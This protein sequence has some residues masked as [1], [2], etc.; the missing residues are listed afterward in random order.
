MPRTAHA[1]SLRLRLFLEGIEVPVIA[2]NVQTAPNSPAVA[3]IQVPPLAS[4]TKLHPRTCVHLFFLDLYKSS[5]AINDTGTGLPPDDGVR[6]PNE[7]ERAQSRQARG[8]EKDAAL[9]AEAVDAQNDQWRLLFGGEVVGFTWTKNSSNR[10]VILQCEDWSN[11]WDYAFQ[12][13]NDGIFGPGVKAVFSGA[14]TN[15]FTDFLSTE[16]E[17][18]T[19]IVSSGKCNT[20]PQLSGLAAGIIRLVEAISG[21][22]YVYPSGNR[23]KPPKRRAGQNLFFSYNELRLHLTQ[24]IGTVQNDPTSERIMRRSGYNGMFQRTIGGQGGQ[25][26]IRK[27]MTAL[28]KIIFYEMFPQPCP[29]YNPGNYGE[30]SGTRRVKMK[31][32]PTLSRFATAANDAI[33]SLDSLAADLDTFGADDTFPA[34]TEPGRVGDNFFGDGAPAGNLNSFQARL[35]RLADNQV[36]EL[37]NMYRLLQRTRA[38]MRNVPQ[39]AVGS[40]SVAVQKVGR[41][42]QK[43]S[44]LRFGGGGSDF[45]G[46]SSPSSDQ[47]IVALRDLYNEISAE[48]QKVADTETLIGVGPD[49]KPAQL[50]QQVFRPDIWFGA[51]PR[52]N[53]LFPELYHTFSYQ[54][55]FLRE[56]TRFMLKTNDEFF[57]ESV[58]FD[59][60]FYAPQAQTVKGNR[61]NMRSIIGRE[62][63]NHERFTGILPIF[64][65]QGEFNIF[66]SQAEPREGIKLVGLA[67]RSANFLYFRHRFNSR[68]ATCVGKFN[69]YLAVGCPGLIIDK[70]VDQATI[71]RHNEL[72][73]QQDVPE[74]EASQILGTNF[75]G[76]FQ[77]V[78]HQISN[79]QPLGET[80]ITLTFPR[81]PD[82]SVEFLGSVPNDARVRKRIDGA[83]AVKSTYVAAID[84]PQLFSLGPNRGRITNVQLVTDQYLGKELETFYSGARRSSEFRPA[85][86]PIGE[87]IT[88]GD[89]GNNPTV[90]TLLG[91]DDVTGVFQAYLVTEEIP[92]YKLEEVLLPPEEYIR[93]GWYGALWTNAQIGKVWQDLFSTGAIT[94]AATITDRGRNAASLRSE[95][96]QQAAEEQK[97]AEN[98]DDPANTA[99]ALLDLEEGATI[100]QAIEFLQLTYSYIRQAGLDTDEFIGA[101]TWRP[102]ASMLDMFGTSDLTYDADG[103]NIVQGFEGFHSRAFGPYEDLFGLVDADIEDVLGVKRGDTAAHNVDVR[104]ARRERVEQYVTALLFGNALLG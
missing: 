55:A 36:R 11:Y 28:S 47:K 56:P 3:T 103:L 18:I 46:G 80:N 2:A 45:F 92:R 44:A 38:Q 5:P 30:V 102:I 63:L 29:K 68:K 66:S 32:H 22:Y 93:P 26:S 13:K 90:S 51:P 101:Y 17:I 60:Y 54:R 104:K 52:C 53:V 97:D 4:A 87:P 98:V 37:G 67:Q 83:D 91:G 84:P 96:A 82:E 73:R 43:A 39:A 86:V 7:A 99:P 58:L 35:R 31:D 62:L 89:V 100:Q 8:A 75:L 61:F 10:S 71:A 41:A 34:A 50:Y 12:A 21:S 40:M 94:D 57:G 16:G 77:Q 59:R 49:R 25:V 9:W 15:L 69:P 20:F 70:H 14:A 27:A 33:Y 42:Q 78:V 95:A 85:K 24:C 23:Q 6:P 76:N 65:K 19:N 72:R 79:P 74:I 81:Q 1:Q 88:A 64:E 48:L